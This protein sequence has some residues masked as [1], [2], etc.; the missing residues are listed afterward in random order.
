[1]EKSFEWSIIKEVSMQYRTGSISVNIGSDT[2]TG[3]GTRWLA[4]VSPGWAFIVVGDTEYYEIVSIN[5]DTQLII[6][7]NYAGAANRTSVAYAIVRDYTFHFGWPTI[8]KGDVS[9]PMILTDALNNIDS[10]LYKTPAGHGVREITFAPTGTIAVTARGKI[11]YDSTANAFYYWNGS[12]WRRLA[13][14][15]V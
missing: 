1:M 10:D 4:A 14:V 6:T 9:W 13:S 5:S 12:S 7:P 11:Y 8:S 2:V 15:A 3:S